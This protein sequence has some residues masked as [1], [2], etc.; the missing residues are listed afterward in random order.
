MAGVLEKSG[1]K[2]MDAVGQSF[3][4]NIHQAMG[5]EP[6]EEHGEGTVI[7]ELQRGYNI[8]SRVLRPALV[9][10]AE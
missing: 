5:S 8:G 10:V 7:A 9:K 1:V 4:P 2:P 6:S 3:D